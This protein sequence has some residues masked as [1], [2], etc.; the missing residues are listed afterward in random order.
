M[1]WKPQFHLSTALAMM[2]VAASIL[3]LNLRPSTEHLDK[4]ETE[5]Q[6]K[7]KAY[8][9]LSPVKSKYAQAIK[10]VLLK[11]PQS[12]HKRFLQEEKEQLIKS[13]EAKQAEK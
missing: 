2:V 3:G 9:S 12:Q 8:Q 4:K 6:K 10:A 11:I 1:N 7:R 13:L 5:A